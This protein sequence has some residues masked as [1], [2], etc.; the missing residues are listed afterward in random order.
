ML[1]QHIKAARDQ[2]PSLAHAFKCGVAVDLDLAGLAE[3][4]DGG[5]NVGHGK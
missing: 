1:D 5:V 4:S 2:L 3:G